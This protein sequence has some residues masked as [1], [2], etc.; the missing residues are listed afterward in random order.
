[1]QEF[2]KGDG[3]ATTVPQ[4]LEKLSRP[5]QM[6]FYY[7]GGLEILLQA[8][9]D[10]ECSFGRSFAQLSFS[11]NVFVPTLSS[12]T[13]FTGPPISWFYGQNDLQARMD[14]LT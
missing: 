5:G 13:C 8:V 12:I 6:P 11:S 7:C 4:L 1:M 10:C 9:A 2:V 3:K 14:T